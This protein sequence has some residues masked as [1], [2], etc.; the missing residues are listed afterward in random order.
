MPQKQPPASTA[1]SRPV[2]CAGA[3]AAGGGTATAVSARANSGAKAKAAAAS[4]ARGRCMAVDLPKVRALYRHE[5][6]RQHV[7]KLHVCVRGKCA[8]NASADSL[9]PSPCKAEI[10]KIYRT[11]IAFSGLA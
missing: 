1:V 6:G 3:S 11:F 10:R 2:A 9:T 7:T 4:K 5:Y 8:P